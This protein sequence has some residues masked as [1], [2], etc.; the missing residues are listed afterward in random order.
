MPV[1][2]P[3]L[4]AT[5]CVA[6]LACGSVDTER[7]DAIEII[8]K[9]GQRQLF[10]TYG[11]GKAAHLIRLALGGPGSR[12]VHVDVFRKDVV[13]DP[14]PEVTHKRKD[15]E[16][17]LNVLKNEKILINVS[18][19]FLVRVNDLPDGSLIRSTF[20][21]KKQGD[22]S[23]TT[24]AATLG[25]KGAPIQ[26]L[27]W[28]LDEDGAMARVDIRAQVKTVMDSD[29]LSRQLELLESAFRLFV[30]GGDSDDTD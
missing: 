3:D 14:F 16:A 28:T 5:H 20:F 8:E 26:G 4:R 15:I 2:L 29:Y 1:K 18:G 11:T 30:L 10:A 23:I 9:Q 24:T 6:F 7:P 25:I 22:L 19:S 12:H 13:A 27:D 17:I 21:A